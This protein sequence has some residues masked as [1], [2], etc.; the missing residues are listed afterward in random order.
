[1]TS[2]AGQ[3]RVARTR[4]HDWHVSLYSVCVCERVYACVCA[5]GCA[6]MEYRCHALPCFHCQPLCFMG[7]PKRKV[8]RRRK[9]PQRE[10]REMPWILPER[11]NVRRS[12]D[13]SAEKSGACINATS[14]GHSGGLSR[15]PSAAIIFVFC[16]NIKNM[17]FTQNRFCRTQC[18]S[19]FG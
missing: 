16:A 6:N 9:D 15:P 11:A 14:A 18:D 4:P 17:L 2:K 13:D 19:L 5:C 7:T 3:S 10:T 8:K 12:A 1:M